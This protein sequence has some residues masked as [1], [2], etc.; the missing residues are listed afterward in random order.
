MGMVSVL[1]GFYC[2]IYIAS[3]MFHLALCG[4]ILETA[5]HSLF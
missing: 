1:E 3:S 2:S 5:I 4:G